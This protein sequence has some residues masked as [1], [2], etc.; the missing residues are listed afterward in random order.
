MGT[1]EQN[2]TAKRNKPS[3]KEQI[4]SKH[5]EKCRIWKAKN[6]GTMNKT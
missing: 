1:M 2:M 3:M 4:Q 6:I 5:G